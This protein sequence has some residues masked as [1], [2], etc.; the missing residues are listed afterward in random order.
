MGIFREVRT[1]VYCDV[2]GG[3]VIGWK[4]TR[5]GTSKSNAKY[6]ARQ[7]GCTTGEKIV[8]KK[9][10]IRRRIE[11][12]RMKKK[13]VIANENGV[14]VCLGFRKPFSDEHIEQCKKCIACT[15]FDWKEELY[16]KS[17]EAR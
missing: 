12:C 4:S 17:I 11:K 6:F 16:K 15:S 2:C 1:A 10:R 14:S 3:Y 13:I 8:C 7:E 5:N 9:C